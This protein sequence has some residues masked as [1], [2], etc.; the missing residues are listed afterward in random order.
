V[1]PLP[2]G[3]PDPPLVD[4]FKLADQ[5]TERHQLLILLAVPLSPDNTVV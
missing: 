2:A 5:G 4:E 1:A 3:T